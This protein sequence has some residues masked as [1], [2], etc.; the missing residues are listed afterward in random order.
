EGAAGDGVVVP[1]L[2]RQAA[3]LFVTSGSIVGHRATGHLEVDVIARVIKRDRPTFI[4][5]AVIGESATLNGEVAAGRGDRAAGA[6]GGVVL[7]H[8]VDHRQAVRLG[9]AEK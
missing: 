1:T 3:S 4:P 2:D 6:I 8:T 9:R 7:Q 5:G